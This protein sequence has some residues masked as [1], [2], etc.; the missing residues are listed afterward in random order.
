MGIK[1][2]LRILCALKRLQNA[3]DKH[4]CTAF[5]IE[6]RLAIETVLFANP[7]AAFVWYIQHENSNHSSGSSSNLG[8]G[9][10]DRTIA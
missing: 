8:R 4:F 2:T 5:S 1:E 6:Y 10:H 7:A 3:A 9:V